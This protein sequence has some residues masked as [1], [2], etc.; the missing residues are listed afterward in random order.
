LDHR[1]GD[2]QGR[3]DDLLVHLFLVAIISAP[4]RTDRSGDQGIPL[5]CSHMGTFADMKRGMEPVEDVGLVLAE[6]AH[7]L[8][9]SSVFVALRNMVEVRRV[10][11]GR[12]DRI[13]A[14]E[15]VSSVKKKLGLE[16]LKEV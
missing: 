16:D 4:G 3:L 2:D 5:H 10:R 1:L 7:A 12:A 9:R 6:L 8:L 13:E 15:V 11:M 14:R